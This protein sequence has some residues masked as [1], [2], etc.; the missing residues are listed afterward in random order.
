MPLQAYLV[1]GVP[2]QNMSLYHRV[3]FATGDPAAYLLFVDSDKSTQH[4]VFI[5][6]DIE[7]D[8]A[9]TTA[10]ADKVYAPKDLVSADH[11]SADR[12]IATSQ[13]VVT[14]LKEQGVGSL[15]IERSTPAI[16]QHTIAQ[17]G[18]SC[19]CD[20]QWGATGRR[21]KSDDEL[22]ALRAAQLVTEIVMRKAC[23]YVAAADCDD[24][25]AIVADKHPLTSERLQTLIDIW[26]LEHGYV[27]STSIVAGGLQGADCH[28]RG[29][30]PLRTGQPIVIDIFPRSKKTHYWGDCTR[31]VVHGNIPELVARMHQTVVAAKQA[32]VDA[33]RAGVT[34]ETVNEATLKVIRD[35]GFGTTTFGPNDDRSL[36]SMVHGTGHGVGLAL[37]EAPLLVSGGPVLLTGDVITIE[38]GLYGRTIGGIRVEDMYAVTDDGCDNFNTIPEGL[39]WI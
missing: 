2:D 6:R 19:V 1:A 13:A 21:Q 29:S 12:E 34:G 17:S 23:E 16:Y 20:P 31:T 7:V 32:A 5:V 30:G 15:T 10:K 4:S 14:L 28:H 22:A 25:G 11:L 3:R 36:I 18:I 39:Q 9:K 26:L 38:P 35:N 27:E 8:R 37:H 33:T 24:H